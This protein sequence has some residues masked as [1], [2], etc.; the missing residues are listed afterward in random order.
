MTAVVTGA[1]LCDITSSA[2][3]YPGLP[4]AGAGALATAGLPLRRRR[5]GLCEAWRH[6]DAQ[7]GEIGLGW[8]EKCVLF[9]L[10]PRPARIRITGRPGCHRS[11]RQVG[12]GIDPQAQGQDPVRGRLELDCLLPV[13]RL[14]AGNPQES[15][16][17]RRE[18]AGRAPS[19]VTA[20]PPAVPYTYYL[21]I[22]AV[23]CS[24]DQG[25]VALRRVFGPKRG[26]LS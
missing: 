12:T 22:G 5:R 20:L 4:R 25:R 18:K 8:T 15:V 11:H 17:V 6:A 14:V 2:E 10:C 26:E 24:A 16:R 23:K 3:D 1:P 21:P 13:E 9:G 7:A 19:D